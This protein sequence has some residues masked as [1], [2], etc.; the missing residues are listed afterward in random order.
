VLRRRRT[1]SGSSSLRTK[2]LHILALA[3]R[4]KK[5]N[6]VLRK[7][8][9]IF[10]QKK[11]KQKK[12]EIENCI[13]CNKQINAH[14]KKEYFFFD[15]KIYVYGVFVLVVIFYCNTSSRSRRTAARDK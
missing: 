2:K 4:Q 11:Q 14:E 7:P 3:E 15:E 8:S 5:K 10:V 9:K 13:S 6:F 1:Q 12:I